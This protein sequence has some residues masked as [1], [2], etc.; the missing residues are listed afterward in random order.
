[1]AI[2]LGGAAHWRGRSALFW[3]V[4]PVLGFFGSLALISRVVLE[5]IATHPQTPWFLGLLPWFGGLFAPFIFYMILTKLPV[6]GRRVRGHRFRMWLVDRTVD[7]EES[8]ELALVPGTLR[9]KGDAQDITVP[10]GGINS[11]DADGELVKVCWRDGDGSS[12]EWELSFLASP[13]SREVYVKTCQFLAE[14][15]RCHVHGRSA[16]W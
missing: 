11:V 13:G 14:R 8:G 9:F 6:Q 16:R 7:L 3:G 15:I 10:A 4:V 1:M 5:Y 2:F 12:R